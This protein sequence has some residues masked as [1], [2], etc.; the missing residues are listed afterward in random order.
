MLTKIEKGQTIYR[1][2][3]LSGFKEPVRPEVV[4]GEVLSVAPQQVRVR[5][6]HRAGQVDRESRVALVRWGCETEREA[7]AG[8]LAEA[9]KR[10]ERAQRHLEA[11]MADLDSAKAAVAAFDARV[12]EAG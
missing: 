5:W 2:V 8:A 12:A 10:V 6:S 7:W 4:S 3:W 9:E 11:E 1:H